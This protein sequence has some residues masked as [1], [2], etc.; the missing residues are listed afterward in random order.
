MKNEK[1]I[2]WCIQNLEFN[3]NPES[4]ED[5]YIIDIINGYNGTCYTKNG[6]IMT[7]S[8]IRN[9]FDNENSEEED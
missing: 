1:I 4:W 5:T 9:M 7:Y 6:K 8:K 2:E 3:N